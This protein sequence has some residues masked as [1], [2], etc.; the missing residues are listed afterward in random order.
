VNNDEQSE[1]TLEHFKERVRQQYSFHYYDRQGK[2]ISVNEWCDKCVDSEY[3]VVKQE[4]VGYYFI[5]TIWIGL[6]ENIFETMIFINEALLKG[7]NDPLME[8]EERYSTEEE[9]FEGHERAVSTA[10]G[11]MIIR[12]I[13]ES[14]QVEI[15]KDSP[16][17]GLDPLK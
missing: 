15:A 10:K 8:Y 17:V 11:A 16:Q 12:K 13:L 6:K 1:E 3:K 4:V 2:Q 7:E 9:A 14:Q 5:S